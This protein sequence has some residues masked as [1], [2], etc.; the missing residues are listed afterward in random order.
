MLG[1]SSTML[2]SLA[3]YDDVDINMQTKETSP[4]LPHYNA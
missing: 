1:A 2:P 4:P 3:S